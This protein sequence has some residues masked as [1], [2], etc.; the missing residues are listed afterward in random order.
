MLGN[1][2]Q[3]GLWE[4]L[5]LY[6]LHGRPQRIGFNAHAGRTNRARGVSV[7]T[8]ERKPK[9]LKKA[10]RRGHDAR[11]RLLPGWILLPC[12]VATYAA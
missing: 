1:A 11:G 12:G 3:Q 6:G 10:P 9:A 4:K 5:A 8:R 7:E 2:S